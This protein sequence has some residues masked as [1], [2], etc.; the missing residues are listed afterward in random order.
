MSQIS[1]VFLYIST[2][3]R[4]LLIYN[5]YHNIFVYAHTESTDN[6]EYCYKKGSRRC[7]TR[8]DNTVYTADYI[9]IW[10]LYFIQIIEPNQVSFHT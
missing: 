9:R 5:F 7:M 2:S 8:K 1:T 3:S 10:F 4:Q 6:I